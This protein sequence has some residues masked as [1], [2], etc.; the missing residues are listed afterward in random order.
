MAFRKQGLDQPKPPPIPAFSAG[1]KRLKFKSFEKENLNALD[2][3]CNLARLMALGT[4][5]LLHV[6]WIH[7]HPVGVSHRYCFDS[8][9][10][11]P[12][13]RFLIAETKH[14]INYHTGNSVSGSG[15]TGPRLPR[16]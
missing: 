6:R 7:P 2:N 4:S 8:G 16:I 15:R 11:R 10:P 13:D 14:E 1:P 3:F 5:H 12:K 9:H